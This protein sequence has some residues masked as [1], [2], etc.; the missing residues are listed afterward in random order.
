MARTGE[1]LPNRLASTPSHM[2]GEGPVGE[3]GLARTVIGAL[4]GDREAALKAASRPWLL[5]TL[6]RLDV[7]PAKGSQTG[8]AL[9]SCWLP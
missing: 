3:A 6:T 5:M 2:S 4:L 1:L 9:T 7:R 8:M